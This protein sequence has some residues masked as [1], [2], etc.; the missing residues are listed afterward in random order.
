MIYLIGGPPK[1][2]KTT[3][4]KKLSRQFHIPWV[5]T[6]TLQS[7]ARAYLSKNE[8]KYRLPLKQATWRTNDEKYSHWSTKKIVNEYRTK[9]KGVY[10]AIE[11]FCISEI[12]DGNDYIV[13]GY[14]VTPQIAA[15][16]MKKYGSKNFMVIFLIRTDNQRFVS[17]IKKSKTPNDWI[18]ARTK[19]KETFTKIS[20]MVIY[21]GQFFR[22][23][24]KKYKFRVLE[25]DD[26]KI[27]LSRAAKHLMKG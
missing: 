23:E 7:V 9:S 24:G 13:E 15:S 18:L 27:N 1:C 22:K 8:Q 21:Y 11:M 12:K 26:F 2:G 3:L 6:D 16:L 14:H 17:D 20:D 25:M 10:P 4:A 19:N 5:S